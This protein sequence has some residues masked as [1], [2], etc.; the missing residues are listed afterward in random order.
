MNKDKARGY[1]TYHSHPP[2]VLSW[3]RVQVCDGPVLDS[4]YSQQLSCQ[5]AWRHATLLPSIHPFNMQG[6]FRTSPTKVTESPLSQPSISSITTSNSLSTFDVVNKRPL[7]CSWSQ[8]MIRAVDL[9]PGFDIPMQPGNGRANMS[10]DHH[11]QIPWQQL[12][13]Q[14]SQNCCRV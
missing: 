14:K 1:Y 6:P 10:T 5:R 3:S 13:Q 9:E 12:K 4:S 2:N 7:E 8:T 11:D